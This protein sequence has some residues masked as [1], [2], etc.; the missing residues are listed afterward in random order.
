MPYRYTTHPKWQQPV[1]STIPNMVYVSTFK[2]GP[3]VQTSMQLT[4]MVSYLQSCTSILR[5]TLAKDRL[6]L[7]NW[8]AHKQVDV[9]FREQDESTRPGNVQTK[10]NWGLF[11]FKINENNILTCQWW[12]INPLH[13]VHLSLTPLANTN[14]AE[15]NGREENY[16]FSFK[17]FLVVMLLEKRLPKN[18][19]SPT[20]RQRHYEHCWSATC[21]VDNTDDKR[22]KINDR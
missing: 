22:T 10:T 4:K 7:Q 21:F 20:H 2:N 11:A 6:K 9:T 15:T 5:P 3:C 8:L 12:P 16:F 14:L 13:K 17:L 19:S 18:I 1:L